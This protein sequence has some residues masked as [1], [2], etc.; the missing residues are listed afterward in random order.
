MSL[1]YA[2]CIG[3]LEKSGRFLSQKSF[4]EMKK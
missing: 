1:Q 3:Y 4:K 2:F